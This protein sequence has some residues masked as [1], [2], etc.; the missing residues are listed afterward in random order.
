MNNR[1]SGR[2]LRLASAAA[3]GLSTCGLAW[4]ALAES[5]P[6]PQFAIHNPQFDSSPFLF[7]GEDVLGTS[8]D[9]LLQADTADQANHCHQQIEDEIERL[10]MVLSTYDPKS[11][12]SQYMNDVTARPLQRLGLSD[13][14]TNILEAYTLWQLRTQNALHINM[15][16]VI[17]LWQSNPNPTRIDLENAFATPCSFN[18]D[19]LGKGYIIDR[20]VE[21]AQK[22]VP[23]GLLNI[24]GDIRS[25]GPNAWRIG[26]ADPNH[27]AENAPPLATFDLKN[28]AVATSGGYAR[29]YGAQ[30]LS[31]L[32]DPRT[33]TPVDSRAA[34]TVIANDCVTANAL[35][36]AA[37]VL[38]APDAANLADQYGTAYLI[39]SANGSTCENLAPVAGGLV[40]DHQPP[41]VPLVA[42]ASAW[43]ENFEVAINVTLK[44]A[45]GGKVKRPYV[46]VWVEDANGKP[47]R[48]ITIWGTQPKY[49]RELSEWWRA[50]KGNQKLLRTITRATREP[51]KYSVTWDGKDDAGNPLPKGDYTIKVEINREH[52]RHVGEL[53]KL[54]C[55]DKKVTGT[56]KATAES[57]ECA[58]VY[59]AKDK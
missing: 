9:L 20:A 18:I 51:G 32:I 17:S 28:A 30:R 3:I 14:L 26:I 19:A 44:V 57:E 36:T 43:P 6:N 47:V 27:P 58:V 38:D 34:A 8:M 48:S 54:A 10:R 21:L 7:A 5:Q 46:A 53:V 13:D 40:L 4:P 24:G 33:L 39:T 12:I 25:W 59:G 42:A 31:H 1:L 52:G 22:L 11:E 2:S 15:A 37:C 16:G 23:A 41:A 50:T 35:S 56:L 29:F 55:Q 49:F 45:R